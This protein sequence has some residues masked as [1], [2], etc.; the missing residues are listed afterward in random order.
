MSD[1]NIDGSG[2]N[3]QGGEN[4]LNAVIHSLDSRYIPNRI[5]D[6]SML[7]AWEYRLSSRVQADEQFFNED[8][9]NVDLS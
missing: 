5:C 4:V 8:S 7:S 1:P 9:G 2:W 6:K 3:L